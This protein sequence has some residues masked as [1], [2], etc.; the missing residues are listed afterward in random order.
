MKAG[1]YEF[2]SVGQNTFP[3]FIPLM[4]GYSE[5]DLKD[6]C[7]A[8]RY[9][10]QDNCPFV[11]KRFESANYI[12]GHVEDNPKL[13]I[14]NYA[15]TGFVKQPVDFYGRPFFAAASKYGTLHTLCH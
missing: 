13:A 3:N 2:C 5:E 1:R 8:K 7:Y 12:T 4:T 11:W 10:K 6:I 14:F 15:K 9:V